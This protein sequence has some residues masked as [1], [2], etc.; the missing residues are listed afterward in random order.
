L[1]RAWLGWGVL[2]MMAGCAAPPVAQAP[3]RLSATHGFVYVDLPKEPPS[4]S[5]ELRAL[6]GERTFALARSE[7]APKGFSAWIPAGDYE[8]PAMGHENKGYA[9]I[10]V[11]AGRM[12]DL[13]GM[14]FFVVGGN[15]RVLLPFRHP[16]F[17]A[18]RRL[19]LDKN[20]PYLSSSEPIEWTPPVPP[21]PYDVGTPSSGLGL[22]ADLLMVYNTHINKPAVSHQ[23]KNAATISDFLS[24]AK[25]IQPPAT[26]PAADAGGNHYYGADFGQVRMR[27]PQGAWQALDTGTLA[28]ITAVAVDGRRLIAGTKDGAIRISEDLGKTWKALGVITHGETIVDIDAVGALWMIVS[29]RTLPGPNNTVLV[30]QIRVHTVNRVDFSDPR[31]LRL[32]ALKDPLHS[33][34]A[35][36]IRAHVLGGYYFVNA[37]EELARYDLNAR[38]WKNVYPGHAVALFAVEP[39]T[40]LVSTFRNQG[41]LSKLSTSTDNGDSWQNRETPPYGVERLH[42]RA[43]DAGEATRWNPGAFTVTMETYR[44]K[45]GSPKWEKTG[46]TPPTACP[47]TI[48]DV[49]HTQV[50]CVTSGNSIFKLDEA[51]K[52]AVEFAV[53]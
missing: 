3:D 21:K 4:G 32:F 49:S 53:N 35:S 2:L 18:G 25:T 9:P 10:R 34:W 48:H 27:D 24:V 5:M 37:F 19:A 36:G 20:R 6:S 42:M 8:I 22:I 51:G 17:E 50:F 16:E 23:L 26:A 13:G 39:K 29:T 40:G 52:L 43:T 47:R 7:F 45:P 11:T 30:D 14:A 12:T 46:E 1:K 15:M 41:F 28:T 38:T 44:L 33:F 31:L